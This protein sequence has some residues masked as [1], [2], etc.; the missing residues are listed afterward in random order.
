MSLVYF[1]GYTFIT[2]YT[3]K[4]FT[5]LFTAW[6]RKQLDFFD[7]TKEL[8]LS[9]TPQVIK[10]ASWDFRNLPSI[11]IGEASG[12][13]K[14]ISFSKD[15]LDEPTATAAVQ[16]LS[17]GGDIELVLDIFVR[18]TSK[19]ECSAL[20]DIVGIYLSNPTAKD[21]YMNQYLKLPEP[22][23]IGGVTEIYEPKIDFPIYETKLTIPIV[24][25]WREEEDVAARLL[26][27]LVTI[28]AEL[29]L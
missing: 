18:A 22:A 24:G 5:Y 15:F 7:G 23:S 13:Y 9:G 11:L 26:S 6:E 25:T 19:D 1:R 27:V 14:T 10:R 17:I 20:A 4:Y 28:S 29:D 16:K 21:W 8:V 2:D 12:K 3:V